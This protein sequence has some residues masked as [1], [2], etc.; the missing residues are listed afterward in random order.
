LDAFEEVVASFE[1]GL[2]TVSGE[3]LGVG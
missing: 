2:V 1:V 3:Y